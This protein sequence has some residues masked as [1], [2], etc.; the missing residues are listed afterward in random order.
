MK[1]KR[2]NIGRKIRNRGIS[3]RVYFTI[4][5]LGAVGRRREGKGEKGVLKAS[6]I[7]SQGTSMDK[8]REQ[9]NKGKVLMQYLGSTFES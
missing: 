4:V 8:L 2:A 9:A 6:K 3:L 5:Y 1:A 7:I